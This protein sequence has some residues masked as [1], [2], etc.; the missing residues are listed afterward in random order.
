MKHTMV[1]FGKMTHGTFTIGNDETPIVII[2][3]IDE[4][5]II[6]SDSVDEIMELQGFDSYLIPDEFT[7]EIVFSRAFF[8]ELSE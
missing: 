3:S 4:K 6:D 1:Y 2:H 7:G 8:K 5:S